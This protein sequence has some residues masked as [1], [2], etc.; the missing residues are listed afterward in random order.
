MTEAPPRVFISYS[1]DSAEHR[2]QV[3]ELANRLRGNGIDAIIDQYVQSPPEGWP[4]WCEAEIR[5]AAFVP[6]V[7]TDYLRRV[8]GEEEPGKGH[9]V[10]WEARL[11][12]Q[13][14]YD[15]ASV[16]GKFVPVLLAD[17]S[18]AHVP[19][20]VKGGTIYRVETPEGYEALLRFL[21]EQP[22]TPMPPLGPRSALPPK[23]PWS[24]GPS[25]APSAKPLASLPHPRVEDLFVGRSA[26]RNAL[27]AA[28]LPASG[29]RRPVVVSG[30]AGVGKSYLVD[31]FFWENMARFPG[32]YIK[33]ALD[34]AN[35]GTAA[36][37]LGGLRDQLQLPA[38]AS[39][40]DR[41]IEP[42]TLLHIENTDNFAGGRLVGEFCASLP[43]CTIVVS[44]RFR[45]LGFAA[46]WPELQ[47][48]PFDAADSTQQLAAELGPNSS[49]QSD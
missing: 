40:A 4:T 10:L 34:S 29:T 21:T 16:S 46:G 28:L 39:P 48:M 45:D 44:A 22:L 2:D 7:C 23:Q 38:A 35:P 9:G 31:R 30:M 8:T 12:R 41:L 1:H 36:D 24:A 5:K 43:G 17:G 47:L 13:H 25:S 6:I 18:N 42:L 49:G 14:L 37:L 20:P 32:G 27:G 15:A 26:E 19:V 11:I 33:L 3:L